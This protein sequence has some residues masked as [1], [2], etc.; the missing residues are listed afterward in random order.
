MVREKTPRECHNH[1]PQPFPDTKRKS[2]QT[3]SNKRK[4]NIWKALRL[5][6]PSP[7]EAIAML[8]GLKTQE[9]NDTS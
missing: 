9:Q 3:K 5:A 1:K 6:L 2:K 4:S 8:K 7:S